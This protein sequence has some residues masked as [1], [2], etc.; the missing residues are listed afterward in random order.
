MSQAA[1][2]LECENN[3]MGRTLNPRDL[4]LSAGGACGGEGVS[5]GGGC[6]V[7]GVGADA[8]VPAAFGGCYGFKP[9]AGRVSVD[10]TVGEHENERGVVGPLARSVD[11]L[12][13][14]MK[15]VLARAPVPWRPDVSLGTFTVAVLWDD[16][17]NKPQPPVQRALRAAAAKLR[18]AGITVVDWEPHDHQRGLDILTALRLPDGGQ[19]YLDELAESG[20][21]PLPSTRH[22]LGMAGKSSRIPHMLHDTA[23]LKREQE[24]YRREHEALMEERGVD[25]ILSP[26]C[27]GVGA[28]QG[29]AKHAHYTSIWGVLDLPSVVL[30]SGLRCD[31]D[32]DVRV[33]A[34]SP[35]SDVDEE[36]WR[37]CKFFYYPLTLS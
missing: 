24:I 23:T 2:G 26:A 14:W 11:G 16:G 33:E 18:A 27:V 15:A 4:R 3:I 35:R 22:A 7:L 28:L 17:I 8:G 32:V 34:Y 6:S 30:P 12:E 29:I 13:V 9:T 19:R 1:L 5:V 21:P 10:G 25:F 36:E 31:K 20:E 37:A